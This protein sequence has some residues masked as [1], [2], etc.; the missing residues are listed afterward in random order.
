[1]SP[2]PDPALD[3]L[4]HTLA[5][6]AYRGRKA[7]L[8][9]PEGFA[10]FRVGEAGTRTPLE[11]L[12]HLGDLFDW[13]FH[14]TQG[15]HVWKPAAPTT[16]EQELDRFFA[17]LGRFDGALAAGAPVGFPLERIYQGP[18]ADSLT[19]IGQLSLLRR[20]AGAPVKGENYFKAEIEKGRVGVEQA[21]PRVEF[22]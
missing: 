12:A 9:A 8:G 19:H 7:L 1:M 15:Q 14:L 2:T 22:D 20:L 17:A 13:A 21:A 3:L 11:I 5:T 6:V 18:I 16:W 10:D 4:R